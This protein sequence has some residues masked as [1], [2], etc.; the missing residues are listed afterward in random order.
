MSTSSDRDAELE[1]LAAYIGR[2]IFAGEFQ[3]ENYAEAVKFLASDWLTAHDRAVR[4]ETFRAAA[5]IAFK[6]TAGYETGIDLL[7]AVDEPTPANALISGEIS[8]KRVDN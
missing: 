7:E 3:D 8:V 5:G 1:S 2:E 6:R 4:N